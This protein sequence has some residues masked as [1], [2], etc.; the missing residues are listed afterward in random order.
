MSNMLENMKLFAQAGILGN[1]GYPIPILADGNGA[2]VVTLVGASSGTPFPNPKVIGFIE[3]NSDTD[4]LN[5]ENGLI[6]AA[7]T[8]GYSDTTTNWTRTRNIT[9]GDL[10]PNPALDDSLSATA[11]NLGWGGNNGINNNALWQRVR[12]A[13]QFKNVVTAAA[14][15]TAVW[16]PSGTFNLMGYTISVSGTLAAAGPLTIEL[17][18][19]ATVIK[20][21]M[22]SLATGTAVGD[23]QIGVSLGARG[24]LSSTVGN[25]L[26]INLSAAL[27]TGAVAINVWGTDE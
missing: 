27:T 5:T 12:A 7:G 1:S 6:V 24:Q 17:L 13:T 10:F 8:Y 26:S 16:A 2:L 3:M 9:P 25:A 11:F 15:T 18:D 20:T 23:T 19:G 14:G 21:H 22:A 4:F